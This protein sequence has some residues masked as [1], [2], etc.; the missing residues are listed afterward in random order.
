M[1]IARLERARD[2]ARRGAWADAFEAFAAV[3]HASLTPADLEALADSAWWL[4]KIDESRE[5][6]QKA[7]AGYAGAG[8][9][10]A[11]AFLAV[12]LCI[13]HF[14]RA[15]RPSG[16]VGSCGHNGICTMNRSASSTD[17]SR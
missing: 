8:D 2:A 10:P 4:S 6:R 14:L 11:A 17:S 7:Y 5:A 9:Q 16:Q 3:D 12:R 13:K 1:E 15:N